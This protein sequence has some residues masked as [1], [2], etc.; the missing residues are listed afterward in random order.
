VASISA[1]QRKRVGDIFDVDFVGTRIERPELPPGIGLHP[2]ACAFHTY[3][4]PLSPA[5]HSRHTASRL[6]LFFRPLRSAL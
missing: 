2:I 3:K 5:K 4:F 6:V 1:L